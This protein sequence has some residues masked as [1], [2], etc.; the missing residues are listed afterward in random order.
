MFEFLKNR[1]NLLIIGLLIVFSM[2]S[3]VTRLL[4][5]FTVTGNTDILSM[6]ASDDPLYNL[7]QI[8]LIIANYP[9]YAWYDPM[10]LYP[11][12]TLI[13]WGSL[14]P[15]LIATICIIVG[16]TTR[17]E[18]IA[19][20]LVIPPIMGMLMVTVMYFIGRIAGDW[21]TG[22]LAAGFTAVVS[23]QFFYR[24]FY[25][26]MDHH[27]AEVLFS[28]IFCLI[29][30][31]ILY[32][33]KDT[34]IKLNDFST[35]K[36]LI[37]M[38]FIAGISYLIG[39][40]I[41]P[42]MV[43]FAMIVGIFTLIQFVIDVL[44]EKSTEY[45][46]LINT[47]VFSTVIIGLISS[48]FKT[49]GM[50]LSAYS[51][52]HVYAYLG[53]M[54][55][56]GI[57]YILSAKFKNNPMSYIMTIGGIGIVGGVGSMF[58]VPSLYN[59]LIKAFFDFFGQM[60]V[61]NTV[62]EAM[63]WT[64]AGAWGAFNYGLYLMIIGAAIMLYQ[65]VKEEHPY[66]IFV[67]VW[68]AIML[69]STKQHIRYEYYLAVN[70]ALLSAVLIGFVIEKGLPDIKLL[71][72]K[73]TIEEEPVVKQVKS[74]KKQVEYKN[75]NVYR[76][77]NPNYLVILLISVTIF[78]GAMFA[79][80][81][82][83]INY[84]SA[85]SGGINMNPDWKSS[86]EWMNTNTPDTGINYTQIYDI[87]TFKYPDAAYGVM[88]WWDYGHLITYIAKRIPNANPFQ[89][90]VVEEA[91]SAHFFIAENESDAN[92]ILD[93]AKTRYIVTDIEMDS[94]KFYAM[95]TWHNQ[96]N[97]NSYQ[98]Y[99][100][101]S[102][103]PNTYS[104]VLLN[105][106]NYYQTM[107]SKLHNF[108]GSYT[109]PTNVSYIEYMDANVAQ[110]G[111]P[112]ITKAQTMNYK[113]ARNA[114]NEFN[115][116]SKVGYHAMASNMII[117]FPVEPVPALR[118]YR[119]VHESSNNIFANA[120][121][122]NVNMKYVKIFEYVKGATIKGNGIIEIPVVTSSGRSFMYKQQSVDGE[123]IV[124][125]STDNENTYDVKTVGKYVI[126]GSNLT[127]DVMENDVMNGLIVNG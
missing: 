22:L 81:S 97:V 54:G 73:L 35:Y 23:G 5:M 77:P 58:F 63:G 50:N 92:V 87:K 91:G 26:Y 74:K 80:T 45:L 29:Y 42:T 127:F 64:S 76:V 46:L 94:G 111:A 53:L 114:V 75:K 107:I 37:N 43:L 105:T 31:Y 41:M 79:Y 70:I 44:R 102:T 4:P 83:S 115:V 100:L 12:G 78:F 17:P 13:Y 101:G 110:S 116:V 108:D 120:G 20:A 126:E 11:T 34:E 122:G 36:K 88:S 33:N 21:K 67:L 125:Y 27:I 19:V 96:S 59:L 84:A 117:I 112:V 71:I 49:Q 16:A 113:D 68:S 56:T 39:M 6:V 86:M 18:I 99:M 93:N 89:Q 55:V 69:I 14:F 62:Q 7:R 65:N 104:P 40:F 60:A 72:N 48:G 24:S 32:S 82:V 98:T 85:M 66:Q 57:L 61:T 123:F 47:V 124:P 10:S 119:L 30:M 25:G 28:S 109:E 9:N 51:I 103:G 2:V 15:T 106:N 1:T 90:G 121:I 38:S 95:A 118:H 8:E 52:G 3:L